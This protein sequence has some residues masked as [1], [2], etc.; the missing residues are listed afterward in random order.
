VTVHKAARYGGHWGLCGARL[1]YGDT[2]GEVP[3]CHGC[4]T[5]LAMEVEAVVTHQP[6]IGPACMMLNC[7]LG[8]HPHRAH[9]GSQRLGD[10]ELP[11]VEP[12]L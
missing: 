11:I 5:L 3:T 1:L 9:A 12:T 2:F 6:E 8:P 10:L 7:K 4:T